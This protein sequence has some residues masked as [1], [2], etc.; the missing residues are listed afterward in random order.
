MAKWFVGLSEGL[1]NFNFSIRAIIIIHLDSEQ[2]STSPTIL[3][4]YLLL[5]HIGDINSVISLNPVF[6]CWHRQVNIKRF[7]VSMPSTCFPIITQM[8]MFHLFNR[9]RKC[10][11]SNSVDL[12]IEKEQ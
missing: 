10:L 7:F 3:E 9:F 8:L 5:K 11:R 1:K 4:N 6:L 12:R 2:L